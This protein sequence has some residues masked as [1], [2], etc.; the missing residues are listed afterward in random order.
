MDSKIILITGSTGGIGKITAKALAKQGHTVVIHG[1]H[2]E[3]TISVCEEIKSETGNEKI[4]FVI[5]DLFLLSEVKQL[6]ELFKKKYE[7]L[8]VLINNAGAIFGKERETTQEGL[9]K[10]MALNLFSPFLLTQL[11]LKVLVKS[12]AARIINVSSA[13]HNMSGKPDLHD[14]Q[15]TKNYSFGNAY[16]LSK[17]YLIWV[18][19]HL[20]TELKTTGMATVTANSLHPGTI[21]TEFGQRAKKGFV[22]DLLFN[23]S[24][25]FAV[26]PEKGA[27]NTIY[28]AT[29]KEVE[30]ISGKYFANKKIAKP[31]MKYYS[32]E[33]EK[34]VWEYC[35]LITQPY[36]G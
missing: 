25:L 27:E 14:I 6:A 32:P 5:A 18:T 8:D 20:A 1:R 12:P 16:G 22:V 21:K 13:A 3:K 4:D 15:S 7:R 29:A 30:Q 2:K 28:L 9:E 24:M 36:L 19:Q 33:N 31:S 34:A 35:K 10:T 23:L 26:S 17:L 11:M